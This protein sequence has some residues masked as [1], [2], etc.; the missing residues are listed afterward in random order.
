MPWYND[1]DDDDYTPRA[2][3][4]IYDLRREGRL[5]EARQ[6]AEELLRQDN[7]DQDVWKAYAWTLIDICKREQ[8]RGNIEGARQISDYL[9]RL[10]FNTTYDEF[11]ETL[12]KKI[13]QLP[14]AVDYFRIAQTLN[15]ICSDLVMESEPLT[16]IRIE[17]VKLAEDMAWYTAVKEN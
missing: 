8:Q 1:W 13:Q 9:S 15:Q 3:T 7:R 6:K 4:E 10:R 11:A 17:F 14:P 16:R 2:S 5:D 12:V